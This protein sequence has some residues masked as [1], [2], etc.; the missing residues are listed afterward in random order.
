MT[1]KIIEQSGFFNNACN[2]LIL[3]AGILL[4]FLFS[5]VSGKASEEPPYEE[6]SVFLS[7]QKVG[8]TEIQAVIKDQELYLPITE[9]FNFL[10]LKNILSPGLDSVTGFIINAKSIYLIDKVLNRI[11]YAGKVY[12]L[13]TDDLIGTETNLYLRS[14]Y[15]GKVFGLECKFH[16]RSLSVILETKLDV[17]VLMEMRQELMR[18]NIKKL[19]GE[20]NADTSIG[21][22]RSFF[23]L[24]MADWSLMNT[25]RNGHNQTMINV[26]L[27]ATVAGGEATVGLTYNNKA[28]FNLRQQ[29][30]L[31][32]YV[33]NGNPFLRQ[34]SIGKIP[35]Q[36]I[37][38]IFAP[39]TGAQFSNKS[40]IR[41]QSFGNY[42]LSNTTEPG[43]TVELYINNVLV[44]YVKADASGFYTFDV[45]L[46][47]GNTMVQLRFFG[48]SGE[49][50]SSEQNMS[51]P[52]N[53]LPVN[54]FEYAVNAGIIEDAKN[55]KFSRA[56]FNYGLSRRITVG[57]GMEFLSSVITGKIMPFV[58]TTARLTSDVLMSAEYA[59]GVR[60][61]AI[62]TYYRPS[63]FQLELNYTKY[64]KA[65]KVINN[66]FL[67]ESKAT[68][69]MPWRKERLFLFSKLTLSRAVTPTISY[70][71][72]LKTK[73]KDIP[74]QKFTTTELM[75][76]GS[77]SK[78]SVN[79]TTFGM[80]QEAATPFLY[81]NLSLSYRFPKGL[82]FRP[83]VQFN[84]GQGQFITAKT[85]VEKQLLSKGFANISFER[86]LS[87]RTTNI[88]LGLRF[89]L[90]FARTA[91]SAS[92]TNKTTTLFQSAS[93]SLLYDATTGYL[94]P[95][96]RNSAGRGGI[97]LSP[98]LDINCNGKREINEPNV[99]GLK[100]GINGGRVIRNEK[101]S[102]IRVVDL[103]PY[104][105][106]LVELD[107]N[108][109]GNISWQI[110]NKK[111][112][113][114]VEPN[115]FKMIEV[116]V[117]VMGEASGMVYINKFQEQK[118][119]SRILVNFYDS[120]SKLVAQTLTEGDGYFSYLGL[121]PGSYIALIDTAQLQKLQMTSSPAV[122]FKIL[123]NID[124]EVVDGLEFILHSLTDTLKPPGAIQKEQ[125]P[126]TLNYQ[127]TGIEK[128]E[129]I[130][131]QPPTIFE[132]KKQPLVQK[133][134]QTFVQ[135]DQPGLQKHKSDLQ[136]LQPV[137]KLSE[138]VIKKQQ[139]SQ[140]RLELIAKQQRLSEKH[141]QVSQKLQQLIRDQQELIKQQK[142]LI[143]RILQLKQ[144]QLR[145][146]AKAAMPLGQTLPNKGQ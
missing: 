13:Q 4:L 86:N 73:Y 118:G 129:A 92:H 76:S 75:F 101:Q 119:I 134:P 7:M 122:S 98:F 112:S 57:A 93:G 18:R 28:P 26:K 33:N 136:K 99:S 70:D 48:P 58:N 24:G 131:Q 69:S 31:W 20:I 34:V 52:F 87:S 130:A 3:V 97:T 54:T 95:S 121:A 21:L 128:K 1:Q 53:F 141:Q 127:Q 29:H 44:D 110:K 16:F 132:K 63:N 117:S 38:S 61:K 104:T 35:L 67:E 142:K 126:V 90:S 143:K 6:I 82:V 30:Y 146:K 85:E 50:R 106:Y 94:T 14:A 105:N 8:G 81:S 12:D 43:W 138:T 72:V 116:P 27:G 39:V 32:R 51:I 11:S 77:V 83:Q 15:F 19:K 68:L 113:V 42:T 5:P 120:R 22:R 55:S 96:N 133:K 56:D 64:A 103:E 2:R 135:S 108:S 139:L 60:S 25:Q 59:H 78:L 65:Q 140:I 88:M 10:K 36:T 62:L 114:V 124:G 100:F 79:L 109:F 91:F 115:G 41:R 107:A 46:I 102:I 145:K 144:Q 37:A 66:N 89:D 45:P 123:S 111:I 137:K 40:T 9:V 71:S 84:Y 125:K 74:K 80:F 47:Y 49:E 23:N 17:P